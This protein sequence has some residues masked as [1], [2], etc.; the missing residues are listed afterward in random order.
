M[1]TI[2]N[3]GD[4]PINRLIRKGAESLSTTELLSI[5]IGNGVQIINPI[6]LTNCVAFDN[7]ILDSNADLT[8]SI[9]TPEKII[10]CQGE[11]NDDFQTI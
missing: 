4:V 9:I 10:N 1:M 3:E 11:Q 7:V 6:T 5:I 2:K 8:Q